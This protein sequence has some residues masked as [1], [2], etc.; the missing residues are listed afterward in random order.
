MVLCDQLD[1][2]DPQSV[3]EYAQ[4]VYQSMRDLEPFYKI[5]HEYIYKK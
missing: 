5:D 2:R 4:E 1:M 3:A